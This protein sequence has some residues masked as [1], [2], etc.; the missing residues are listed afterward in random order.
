MKQVW[1]S[2]G[3]E[4]H[5]D[6]QFT[7]GHFGSHPLHSTV[8]A[9]LCVAYESDGQFFIAGYSE[10]PKF[11]SSSTPGYLDIKSGFSHSV[12]IM[13]VSASISCPAS[14]WKNE[15][16]NVNFVIQISVTAKGDDTAQ[17][18]NIP[19]TGTI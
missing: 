10:K 2:N 5:L 9:Y 4:Y 17:I 18:L 12:E 14:E 16:N 3:Q 7:V 15:G 1:P 6:H 19:V 11:R 8:N 13:G